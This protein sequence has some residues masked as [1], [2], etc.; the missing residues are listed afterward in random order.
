M[1]KTKLKMM[2]VI[3][4]MLSLTLMP[5]TAASA[6]TVR[7]SGYY[8]T[9]DQKTYTSMYGESLYIGNVKVSGNRIT[10]YGNFS[11]GKKE[12]GGKKI[13]TQ[14]RT[15]I[16]SPKCSYWNDWGVPSGM[17]RM[18]KANLLRSV[19]DCSKMEDTGQCFIMKVKNGKVVKMMIGQA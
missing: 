18:K 16:I 8:Y 10:T 19:K 11:Y 9:I 7:K 4:L 6:K 14:K 3:V 13:K 15:F 17:S 5:D 12:W 2:L 1:H